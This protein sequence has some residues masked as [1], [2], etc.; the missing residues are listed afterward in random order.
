MRTTVRSSGQVV[1]SQSLPLRSPIRAARPTGN[2]H[3]RHVGGAPLRPPSPQHLDAIASLGREAADGLRAKPEHGTGRRAPL[4]STLPP[5]Q[6]TSR[7]R[8]P[9]TVRPT[10]EHGHGPESSARRQPESRSSARTERSEAARRAPREPCSAL[11]LKTR[12]AVPQGDTPARCRRPRSAPAQPLERLRT[13]SWRSVSA[14]GAGARHVL[15]KQPLSG[16]GL[17]VRRGR[18]RSK[19]LRHLATTLP[20]RSGR[21]QPPVQSSRSQRA[22]TDADQHPGTCPEIDF[23]LFGR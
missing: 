7:A 19:Q 1:G 20:P 14:F 9:N 23:P 8:S 16:L 12:A 5:T 17:R 15:A 13:M 4:A 22:P 21:A 3:A 2:H 10:F 11:A 18:S 6:R